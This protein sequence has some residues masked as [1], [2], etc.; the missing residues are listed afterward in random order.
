VPWRY[1]FIELLAGLSFAGAYALATGWFRAAPDWP[2]LAQGAVF[3]SLMLVM[4][5]I[6]LEHMLL[7]NS[8]NL[9]GLAAGLVFALAGAGPVT[10]WPAVYGAALGYGLIF[11]IVLV[12]RGGM[13]MGDAKFLAMIGAFVGLWACSI[14]CSAPAPWAPPP[15]SSSSA[16]AVTKPKSPSLSA[17]SWP[18]RRW[19][20][21]PGWP[22]L[23]E[24]FLTSLQESLA[25]P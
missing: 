22:D 15:A 2:L 19:A 9:I 10:I 6:D 11:V 1:T 20:S 4:A 3:A 23:F 5:V 8:V 18:P 25:A 7:P 13:G 17:P 14:R 21:G 16:R 12:S 24:I